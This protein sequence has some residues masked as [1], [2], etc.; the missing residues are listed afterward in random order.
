MS[1]YRREISVLIAIGAIAL[2]L[3]ISA[4]GYFGAENLSDLFLANLPVLVVAIG[5][6]LVILTGQI[7]VSSGS[8]FA[9]LATQA[10]SD[11]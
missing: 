10:S 8:V 7:D 2:V 5:M 11:D 3:A 6:T 4:P 9:V 1:S